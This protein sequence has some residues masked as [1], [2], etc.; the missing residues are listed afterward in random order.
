M[1]IS[2]VIVE[3]QKLT[4]RPGDILALRV[5][6]FLSAEL[7]AEMQKDLKQILPE[8]ANF[9]ILDPSCHFQVIEPQNAAAQEVER[10]ACA[11]V[12]V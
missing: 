10:E 7:V 9:V 4:L 11:K 8:G 2:A 5:D 6:R 3:V 1:H 12:Y